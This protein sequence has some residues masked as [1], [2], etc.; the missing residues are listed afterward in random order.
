ML[1]LLL[2]CLHRHLWQRMDK[3]TP[4][5]GDLVKVYRYSPDG[6]INGHEVGVVLGLVA[7]ERSVYSKGINCQYVGDQALYEILINGVAT[8]VQRNDFK[9]LDRE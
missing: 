5:P 2:L 9:L 1:S 3:N 7:S 4:E 6:R 8:I